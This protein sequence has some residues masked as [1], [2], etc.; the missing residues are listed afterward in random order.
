VIGQRVSDPSLNGTVLF[1][2]NDSVQIVWTNT[3]KLPFK[4]DTYSGQV[5]AVLGEIGGFSVGGTPSDSGV[6]IPISQAQAFFGTNECNTIIVKLKNSD[7]ATIDNVSQIITDYFN[8]EVTV[9]SA[10][11]VLNTYS[12]IFSTM[13][14]FLGGIAAISLVVAGIGIMNIMIVSLIER[15]R[16]IGVLKALGMKSRTVLA[17]FLCEAVIIGL[18]GAV[19]G[20]VAG[21]SLASVVAGLGGGF[22]PAR[23]TA[24]AGLTITPVLTPTVFLGALAFGVGI[25]V[26]FALYPAW[27]AAKVRP[28]EAMRYE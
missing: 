7:Q 8:G 2:L 11:A 28:S 23:L 20:V 19:I 27:R 12:T 1:G 13:Q 9:Q 14:F 5:S 18:I 3:N 16:E 10:T 15:T 24:S 17:I 6:Y 4:N 22:G 25:S 26:V 21:W